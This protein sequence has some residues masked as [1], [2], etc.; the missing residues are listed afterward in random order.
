MHV[1]T[2]GHGNQLKLHVRVKNAGSRPASFETSD[3]GLGAFGE[4]DLDGKRHSWCLPVGGN[5]MET[6]T[7][8]PGQEYALPAPDFGYGAT[9]E[10]NQLIDRPET[11]VCLWLG[12][13]FGIRQPSAG[14][15]RLR[16]HLRLPG[17]ETLVSNEIILSTPSGKERGGT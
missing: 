6:V 7:L 10:G 4:V 16:F 11:G 5:T 15:H 17:G 8:A 14:E 9:L 3:H 2:A 12:S 1:S 13:E